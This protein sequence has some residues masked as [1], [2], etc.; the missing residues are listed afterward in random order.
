M[1]YYK[2]TNNNLFG[3]ETQD[4]IPANITEITINEVYTINADKQ[5]AAFNALTYAE[6][7]VAEYPPITDYIDGIV[8]GDQAQV[9][10]YIDKCIA[11]KAKY[12]KD[13]A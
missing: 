6:K 1:K 8:K 11:V 7:R 13:A 5:K 4:V 10:E 3:F 9:Q 2:D 12:P